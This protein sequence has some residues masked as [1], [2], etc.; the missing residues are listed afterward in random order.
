PPGMGR[1]PAY[2]MPAAEALPLAGPLGDQL[3]RA[4]YFVCGF[5]LYPWDYYSPFPVGFQSFPKEAPLVD[6]AT[7]SRYDKKKAPCHMILGGCSMDPLYPLLFLVS[8]AG[9]FCQTA[10]GFGYTVVVMLFLP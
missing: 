6:R 1:L 4:R 10:L 9:G 7:G 3:D 5:L 2:H 8:L